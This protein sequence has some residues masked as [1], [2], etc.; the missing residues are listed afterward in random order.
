MKD[1]FENHWMS[2]NENYMRKGTMFILFLTLAP[3]TAI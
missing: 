2:E 1:I 3:I